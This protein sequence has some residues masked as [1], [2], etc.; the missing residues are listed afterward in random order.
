MV[1]SGTQ[2]L[3]NDSNEA[4]S[5][6]VLRQSWHST[7]DWFKSFP[8]KFP[9]YSR[10][11]LPALKWIPRYDFKKW[12]IGDL[13]AGITVGIMV[14]PQ[15]L[16]YAKV[17]N[18]PVQ[19]GLYSAYLGSLLYC[20][21]GTSKDI[22]LGPTAVLSL[23]TGQIVAEFAVEGGPTPAEVATAA[24]F[25]SGLIALILGTFKL[26]IILDFFPAP[27]LAG[28]TT[29]AAINIAVSQLPKF[30]GIP[31]VNN[32]QASYL[33]IKDTFKNITH[34]S[35]RD[36]LFGITSFAMLY[37]IEQGRKRWG[38][39][40][41]WL[42][43]LSNA[44]FSVTVIIFTIIAFL[45][46]RN[47][48][49]KPLLS[50]IKTVPKGLYPPTNPGLGESWVLKNL[51]HVITLTLAS[52][53]EH[54]AISKALARK[55]QYFVSSDQE[56][57][58]IGF[59]NVIGSCFG[60]API[61][62]SFSRSA[63]S[64][65]SG[66]NSPLGG[67][68]T[69]VIVIISLL[70]LTPIFFYIPES[71]LSAIIIGAVL[72]LILTYDV[73]I[74]L[75]RISL[76]DFVAAVISLVL[77]VFISVEVGIAAGTGLALV[78]LLYRVARPDWNRLHGIRQ[79]P[80]VYVTVKYPGLHSGDND[81][82]DDDGTSSTV[83]SFYSHSNLVS[84]S[85]RES[86]TGKNLLVYE[87]VSP[88]PGILVI[89]VE[90]ALVFP[91]MEFFQTQVYEEVYKYTS[92]PPSIVNKNKL[93][94]DDLEGRIKRLRKETHGRDVKDDELPP[95]KA[96]VFDFC[97]VNNMDSSGL[98]GLFDL[99][100]ILQ[101]EGRDNST[102]VFFEIH[103]VAVQSK[104]LRLI[105]LS[106]ISRPIVPITPHLGR[107]NNI[108]KRLSDEYRVIRSTEDGEGGE[109]EEVQLQSLERPGESDAGEAL[110]TDP[111]I[112]HLT[113]DEAIQAIEYRYR[114][115]QIHKEEM[116]AVPISIQ[117]EESTDVEEVP[118]KEEEKNPS[119]AS[120]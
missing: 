32:R 15:G 1:Q 107:L 91:N 14:V 5:V 48:T 71:T 80:N 97:A 37:G 113:I 95:L 69:G 47:D 3:W 64:A 6:R 31:G 114:L 76:L 101:E 35:W 55:G 93:W 30:L 86:K 83:S 120:V 96:I 12:I 18:L 10:E 25:F 70:F 79:K 90:E 38:N 99:H 52:V 56:L 28:Y 7:R 36:L 60:A 88:P 9:H 41:K 59:T 11:K 72:N 110:I 65:Q 23:I 4:D 16:A 100:S 111:T 42:Q 68:F 78:V 115:F 82:A 19:Y 27:V 75:W 58:A 53:L 13:I 33:V 54:I 108:K 17:A 112:I 63:V 40:R 85:G 22:N 67:L 74:N 103:F 44:R 51:G 2:S 46:V 105:E 119:D 89:R 61:T 43:I 87:L 45:V 20:F 77:T 94:S 73:F 104:V 34:I 106:G 117:S 102:N 50:I 66:V 8:R 62:G 57:F 116:A 98:Q 49:A 29:G 84:R 24:A 92:V 26:G 118:S 21:I 109:M 39:K 81:S